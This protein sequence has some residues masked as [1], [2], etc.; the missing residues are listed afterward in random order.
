VCDSNLISILSQMGQNKCDLDPGR[1]SPVIRFG[2]EAAN[3]GPRT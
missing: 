2:G 3:T 1:T